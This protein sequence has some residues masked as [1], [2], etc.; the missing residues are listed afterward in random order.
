[1]G[2]GT[3][4]SIG[5]S[6]VWTDATVGIRSTL[7]WYDDYIG[8]EVYMPHLERLALPI[9]FIHGGNNE[10]FLPQSTALTYERLREKN[11]AFP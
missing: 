7:G 5:G 8:A 1:M 4:C 3:G 9:T 11:G 6:F 2:Y 10:C